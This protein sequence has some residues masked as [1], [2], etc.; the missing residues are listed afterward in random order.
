MARNKSFPSG[1]E[2]SWLRRPRGTAGTV[3]IS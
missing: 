2:K 3:G 1:E